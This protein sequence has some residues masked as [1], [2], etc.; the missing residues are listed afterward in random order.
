MLL[1]D[2]AYWTNRVSWIMV[3][4]PVAVLSRLEEEGGEDI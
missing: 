3:H 2:H 1:Q 4:L